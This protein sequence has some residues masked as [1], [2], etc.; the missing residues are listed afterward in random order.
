[1]SQPTQPPWGG[2]P[3][4]WGPPPAPRPGCVPLRP[5][6]LGDILDG[7]FTAIRRNP[8]VMLGLSALIAVAQAV[9]VAGFSFFTFASLGNVSV[10]DPGDATASTSLGPL[11]GT[12]SVQFVGLVASTL[13]GS[14]LTGML[15]IAI[16]QDVLGVTLTAG[17]V[18]ER[19]RGRI[20]PLLAIAVMTTIL[21][22]AGLI[23]FL[24]PGIW[25][26][27]IWAVAVPALMV[28]R[29]TIRGALRRSKQLVGGTFWRVWGVRALGT[30]IATFIGG[31][32]VVPF[33]IVGLI[34]DSDV[35]SGSADSNH[36]PVLFLVLTAIGSALSATFTAPIRAGI[37]ALLY[38]DLRMRK[39]GLDIALRHHVLQPNPGAPPAPGAP[40]SPAVTAF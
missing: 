1:M 22:F 8:R 39:E 17:Q 5:L 13:L 6:G 14:I 9:I 26:W 19:V 24:A 40:P 18:W 30:L 11:V 34:V 16:T 25:L 31:F 10:T 32:L 4:M 15:T 21:E 2:P 28:E 3:P 35:F 7:S 23:F 20:W 38:V 37:D 29:T 12:E 33:E 27:G 36:V